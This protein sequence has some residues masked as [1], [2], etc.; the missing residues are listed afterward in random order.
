[1]IR[2]FVLGSYGVNLYVIY[3][4]IEK[5][6][7]I[8][9]P[10]IYDSKVTKFIDGLNLK[11]EYIILTH[12]HGDHLLGIDKYKEKYKCEIIAHKSEKE[13]LSNADLNFSKRMSGESIIIVP[14]KW[15]KE[16]DIISIGRIDLKVIH[17]PG[18]TK[19]GI[20]LLND[21]FLISGDTLF[22]SSIGRHDLYGGN[23]GVLMQSIIKKLMKLNDDL[24]VYP[25]H[26]SETT[27]GFEKK[28][29]PFIKE[30]MK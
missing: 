15:L 18:H 9:D 24:I 2:K 4:E 30:E 6:A 8:V 23:Y 29:N 25:G 21:D 11:V 27:I 5:K 28:N 26:G 17:T 16:D 19:G 13:L 20:C 1:M 7:A 22:Y 12:G 3:D 10:A 14:D